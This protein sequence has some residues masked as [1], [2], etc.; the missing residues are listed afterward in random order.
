VRI[1][2]RAFEKSFKS[3]QN[4][5]GWTSPWGPLGMTEEVTNAVKQWRALLRVTVFDKIEVYRKGGWRDADYD[6]GFR[7]KT[8]FDARV[9]TRWGLPRS[10]HAK[11]KGD[12]S[13]ILELE[14]AYKSFGCEVPESLGDWWAY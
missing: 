9:A 11:V 1:F 13:R 5:P 3:I 8:L 6:K 4:L 10:A 12:V 7:V 2:D 14:D